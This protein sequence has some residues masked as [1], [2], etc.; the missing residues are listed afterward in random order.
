MQAAE[1]A[2]GALS[3]AVLMPGWREVAGWKLLTASPLLRHTLVVA[4]ADH[5]YCDGSSHQARDLYRQSPYDTGLL[6]LQTSAAAAK[7]RISPALAQQLQAALA[8]CC[9]TAAAVERQRKQRGQNDLEW[10]GLVA[11]VQKAPAPAAAAAG[12]ATKA[13]ARKKQRAKRPAGADAAPS[14]GQQQQSKQERQKGTKPHKKKKR[15][16]AAGQAMQP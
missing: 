3:F 14:Q 13:A 12:G 10:R 16:G 15:D 7:W 11:P 8:A 1:A 2:G 9:P 4:A 6:L 5:G